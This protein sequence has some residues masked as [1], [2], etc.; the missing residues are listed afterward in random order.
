MPPSLPAA[1]SLS[2]LTAALGTGSR[3]GSEFE[4]I[5]EQLTH[6]ALG[7]YAT[8]TLAPSDV[9]LC[10]KLETL[11]VP[12]TFV[13]RLARVPGR[14]VISRLGNVVGIRVRRER[15]RD[16]DDGPPPRGTGTGELAQ[17]EASRSRHD[18]QEAFR[19]LG[20]I[21][22]DHS[23]ARTRKSAFVAVPPPLDQEEPSYSIRE[24]RLGVISGVDLV[25]VRDGPWDDPDVARDAAFD[26]GDQI[27]TDWVR[28]KVRRG[29]DEGEGTCTGCAEG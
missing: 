24:E 23:H 6:L 5:A 1:A 21:L 7:E 2:V 9:L 19:N 27:W 12:M 11:D 13:K 16:R 14:E 8:K 22:G 25:V 29:E 3:Q 4:A 10:S 18:E 20:V 26:L 17:E 28:A 15:V